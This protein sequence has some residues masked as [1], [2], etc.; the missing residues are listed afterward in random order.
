VVTTPNTSNAAGG[1]LT[2]SY[3]D[4]AEHFQDVDFGDVDVTP[5]TNGDLTATSNILDKSAIPFSFTKTDGGAVGK[6]SKA[7]LNKKIDE[8]LHAHG[9]SHIAKSVKA[10]VHHG[11]GAVETG[12]LSPAVSS[13]II[14]LP[15]SPRTGSRL[16]KRIVN[17]P[18]GSK[19]EPDEKQSEKDVR[20]AKSWWRHRPR[21]E[22][23]AAIAQALRMWAGARLPV[24]PTSS[25]HEHSFKTEGAYTAKRFLK[26]TRLMI[27]T[28][29]TEYLGAVILE[30]ANQLGQLK[31][32]LPSWGRNIVGV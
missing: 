32:L 31:S 17:A 20:T 26:Q 5:I 16:N 29:D 10:L 13:P 21:S 2:I 7:H 30:T 28:K 23:R 24:M 27:S 25:V 19:L 6:G 12:S 3:G 8:L 9:K 1:D 18:W 11:P 15:G 22:R 4:F 14:V